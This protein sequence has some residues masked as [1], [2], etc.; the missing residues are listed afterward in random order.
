MRKLMIQITS[1]LLIPLA[2][3]HSHAAAQANRYTALHIIDPQTS[4][5]IPL[6]ELETTNGLLF[7]TDNAGDIAINEPEWRGEEIYFSV[8]S[9]G[10]AYKQDGFGYAGVKLRIQAGETHTIELERTQLA[11]RLCRLTG[12]GRYRDSQL[13]GKQ[14]PPHV[15]GNPGKV[16]GQDS[17]E[18]AIYQNKVYWFWG[19]TA[20]MS[21]PLGMFRT[22][23]ATT[24]LSTLQADGFDLREGIPYHYFTDAETGF[25]RPMMPHPREP[26]GVIWI[27]GVCVVPDETGNERM[28]CHYSR[29][30]GLAS[31]LEQGIALFND[32]KQIFESVVVLPPEETWRKPAGHPVRFQDEDRDW[33]LFGKPT[34]NVRLPARLEAILD[35][36]QY[37]A[38][39][40]IGSHQ[41]EKESEPDRDENGKLNWRWQKQLKPVDSQ[42]E[43]KWL[44]AGSITAE[45]CRFLP[46]DVENPRQ[47]VQ[48]HSGSV[49]WNEYRKKWIL[50]VGQINGTSH[51][52]EVWYSEADSPFGPFR[53][54]LKVATHDRQT[55]YNVCH[56]SFLDQEGG[57][58]I[59]FEGTY[60]NHF[61]GNPHKTPRY[62][63]NQVLY[64]LDL[65][66]FSA[67][68]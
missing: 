51:L 15:A 67:A 50:V 5:G 42:L 58:V 53:Q 17:I 2:V 6:V 55:F 20:R 8:K 48:L 26:K 31:E 56:H 46:S 66:R 35:P 43:A 7:V 59:H 18:T 36:T 29:R 54:A 40:C 68:R 19:D 57:R 39:T 52:G 21:Y 24:Q 38:L 22:A 62:N 27:S 63:Y 14:I 65:T 30:P 23:G 49:N 47:H 28:I 1:S 9:H 44:K 41:P 45:E 3:V 61:S 16:A 11:E 25:V 4:H 13:L 12:E 34:P 10:Y 37:E 32:D 64:R 60:T 33:M